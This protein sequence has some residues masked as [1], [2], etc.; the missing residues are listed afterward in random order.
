MKTNAFLISALL[1]ICLGL[2][3]SCTVCGQDAVVAQVKIEVNEA[4]KP[5]HRE[6]IRAAVKLSKKADSGVS[7]R[8]VIRLRVAMLSPAFRESAK[9]LA[10]VQLYF[11]G[12]DLPTN[13]HGSIAVDEIKWDAEQWAAFLEKLV[14]IILMLLQIFGK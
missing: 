14:P 2:G 1:F 6:L 8:D 10:V 13:E 12:S 3:W 11:N 4:E 5:F 7:R 9:E